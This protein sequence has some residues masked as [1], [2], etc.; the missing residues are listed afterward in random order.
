VSLVVSLLQSLGRDVRVHLC[1][2]KMGMAEE[3][4]HTAKVST[5]IQQVRGVTVT[6]LVRSQV[7]IEAS[8]FQVALE[9][10]LQ[11]SWQ[12]RVAGIG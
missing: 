9:P 2:H 3:F 7:R 1:G 6:K 4:L 10:Q 11:S 8:D 12:H 5:G